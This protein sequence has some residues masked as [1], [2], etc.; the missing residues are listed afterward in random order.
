MGPPRVTCYLLIYNT[1]KI[2]VSDNKRHKVLIFPNGTLPSCGS[3][4]KMAPS[5][6]SQKLCGFYC[7]LTLPLGAVVWPVECDF[8]ISWSYSF[9]LHKTIFLS[10]I[11]MHRA[12]IFSM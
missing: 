11:T 2:F 7:S 6:R 9:F 10:N 3:V 12:L 1:L 5:W 4:V 8:G